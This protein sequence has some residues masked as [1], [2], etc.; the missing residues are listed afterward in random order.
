[1]SNTFFNVTFADS[2]NV[3]GLAQN[4]GD[5]LLGDNSGGLTTLG[6]GTSGQVLTIDGMTGQ[7]TWAANSAAGSVTLASAGGT[8]LVTDGVGP[9]LEILGLS[10]GDGIS[11]NPTPSSL[12]IACDQTL[13]EAYNSSATGDVALDA[14]RNGLIL[15]EGAATGEL[16]Q[17]KNGLTNIFSV[18]GGVSPQV[19]VTGKLNVTGLIDPTGLV[20]NAQ[21]A[22]PYAPAVGEGVLWVDSASDVLKYQNNGT[23]V[24]LDVFDLQRAYNESGD[25]TVDVDDTNGPFAINKSVAT[26]NLFEVKDGVTNFVNVDNSGDLNVANNLNVSG[27]L[28]VSGT[29]TTV[30]TET[31]NAEANYICLNKNYNSDAA[32]TCGQVYNVD[33]EATSYSI[34]SFGS[35][36]MVSTSLATGFV[37]G[38]LVIIV[39]ANNDNNNGIFEISAS[40]GTLATIKAAGVAADY[41]QNLFTADATAGGTITRTSLTVQRAKTN[42][43]MEIGSG[44]N[45]G[46]ITFKEIV[47]ELSNAGVDMNTESLV[48]TNTGA[49]V[50][51]KGL[52]AGTG[53]TLSSNGTDITINNDSA[54]SSVTL[55]DV[56]PTG[57][58]SLVSD[59]MGPSLTIK[60]LTAGTGVT[61]GSDVN[62]ITINNDSPASDVT[63]TNAGV[64][65]GA[66]SLVND[67]TGPAV[68]TKGVVGAGGVD[69]SSNATDVTVSL[70]SGAT[71]DV[72]DTL[73]TT[74]LPMIHNTSA[75]STSLTASVFPG[76]NTVVATGLI[77]LTALGTTTINLPTN[78]RMLV[79]RI[80]VMKTDAAITG[81]TTDAQY[82]ITGTGGTYVPTQ[83]LN[84]GS[85]ENAQYERSSFSNFSTTS[86]TSTLTVDVTQ[87]GSFTG[88]WNARVFFEGK[89]V[90]DE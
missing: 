55:N 67:G 15:D 17:V 75:T 46:S 1:M 7:P 58:E 37:A 35:T 4:E 8:S 52:V 48:S 38:D 84:N 2:A 41:V 81:S 9:D 43:N 27:N 20:L 80:D 6:T 29:T 63:L 72:S 90:R 71:T 14:T 57:D 65:A 3:K 47:T 24:T 28:T 79:D 82:T 59:D 49:T 69:V 64:A 74:V 70:G 54:A 73:V 44:S 76:T 30:N 33:P 26:G 11:F 19:T 68:A 45:T 25:G 88:T 51:T 22:S 12:E 60:R 18:T 83:S 56:S 77:S 39:G 42:G 10:A 85:A 89:L 87:A 23:T 66:Q 21:G 86:A 78:T 40:A 32:Q 31:I 61:L 62:Q 36:S 13:Q 5:L 53:I 50:S 16:L 34:T